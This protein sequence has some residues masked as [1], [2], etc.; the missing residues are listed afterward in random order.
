MKC[1]R[2]PFGIVSITLYKSIVLFITFYRRISRFSDSPEYGQ[3]PISIPDSS[4][5]DE[6]SETADINDT[7]QEVLDGIKYTTKIPNLSIQS[8]NAPN[9]SAH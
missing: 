8:S 4:L 7:A 2:D 1:K 5:F 6:S 9:S 3:K